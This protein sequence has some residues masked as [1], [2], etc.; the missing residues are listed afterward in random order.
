MMVTAGKRRRTIQGMKGGNGTVTGEEGEKGNSD[1][2]Q[3]AL[4]KR[5][6][7]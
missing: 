2:A 5:R 3:S 1:R 4:S 6:I 7:H